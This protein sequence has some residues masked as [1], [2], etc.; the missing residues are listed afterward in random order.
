MSNELEELYR[1]YQ[2]QS[3]DPKSIYV[4]LYEIDRCYGG[5]EEGG[6]WYDRH[7][8]LSSKKFYDEEEAEKFR[9]FL[10][11]DV[12]DSGANEEDL[13]SSKGFD[14]YPDP[15]N[16]DPMYDHSDSD[17]PIGFSGLASNQRVIIEEVSGERETEGRPQYEQK[18]CYC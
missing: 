6:W 12:E 14:Q 16:G 11:K 9:V 4:S 8:L 10:E 15:S 18:R 3:K 7:T 5:P 17:I 13:S 1:S 2:A